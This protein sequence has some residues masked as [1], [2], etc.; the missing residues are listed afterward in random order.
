MPEKAKLRTRAMLMAAVR[1]S[2]TPDISI[3]G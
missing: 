2:A 3:N 1:V